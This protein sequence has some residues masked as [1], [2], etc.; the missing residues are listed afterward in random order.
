M[1][2]K[3]VFLSKNE[4]YLFIDGYIRM[5]RYNGKY[6]PIELCNIIILYYKNHFNCDFIIIFE[7]YANDSDYL[8]ECFCYDLKSRTKI[9]NNNQLW[10]FNDD[11]SYCV[12]EIE[13]DYLIFRVGGAHN[14]YVPNVKYSMKNEK[15]DK[16]PLTQ[17]KRS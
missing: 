6:I 11:T 10:Q 8:N 12:Y 4:K 9:I 1:E 13:N 3:A 7:K 15:Y 16:L 14:K 17:T 2:E 5:C